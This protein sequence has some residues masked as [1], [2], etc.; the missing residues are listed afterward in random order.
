MQNTQIVVVWS[1][2][3]FKQVKELKKNLENA[4]HDLV[5]LR[6]RSTDLHWQ[7]GKIFVEKKLLTPVEND[8]KRIQ[9]LTATFEAEKQVITWL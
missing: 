9:M 7:S 2:S 1:I 4:Q 5:T 6:D 8:T 3:G